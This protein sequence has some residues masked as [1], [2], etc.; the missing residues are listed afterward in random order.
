[1]TPL[2]A[3]SPPGFEDEADNDDLIQVHH[4]YL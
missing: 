1:M 2:K 4:I 3:L